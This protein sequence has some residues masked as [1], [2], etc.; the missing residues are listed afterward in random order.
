MSEN[1]LE[2][3][4]TE[5]AAVRGAIDDLAG[6]LLA[7]IPVENRR[8][9]WAAVLLIIGGPLLFVLTLA[10]GIH[11][12]MVQDH[13]IHTLNNGVRCL[14]ADLD[15]HR[16]TNQGA[17]DTLAAAHGIKIVQPDLIPLTRAQAE[18]LKQACSPYVHEATGGAYSPN[19]AE[20][21]RRS[22]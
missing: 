17:H 1:G 21:P 20:E 14:L 9:R 6:A 22:P 8:V 3:I 10:I 7:S 12:N 19:S 18:I 13:Q 15:D 5:L 11:S 2:A 16:H 4:R